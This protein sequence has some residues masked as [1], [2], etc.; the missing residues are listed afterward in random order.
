ML[1]ISTTSFL[2]LC[3]LC[4]NYTS[5][6]YNL[7]HIRVWL[8]YL[9]RSDAHIQSDPVAASYLLLFDHLFLRCSFLVVSLYSDHYTNHTT[10]SFSSH[11][12]STPH[13]TYFSLNLVNTLINSNPLA[14]MASSKK[15]VP[16]ARSPGRPRKGSRDLSKVIGSRVAK[17]V[18]LTAAT[19]L[20][21][22]R[23]FTPK[24]PTNKV[25]GTA[26]G[27]PASNSTLVKRG[28]GRPKK[29]INAEV[30]VDGIVSDEVANEETEEA[31]DGDDGNAEEDVDKG[32]PV[33]EVKRGRGR[34]K[35]ILN[36]VVD[37]DGDET[38]VET[39]NDAIDTTK[40][41][42]RAAE[43]GLHA[44]HSTGGVRRG[45]GRPKIEDNAIDALAPPSP[46]QAPTTVATVKRGRGRPLKKKRLSY[47]GRPVPALPKE[48]SDHGGE[49]DFDGADEDTFLL[50][51]NGPD[52]QKATA[53]QT[54]NNDLFSVTS[55]SSDLP[56]VPKLLPSLMAHSAGKTPS[57]SYH[58]EE[59]HPH[60]MNVDGVG[61][62]RHGIFKRKA[63]E[64]ER[65][66][67]APDDD[68]DH[69]LAPADVQETAPSRPVT[70]FGHDGTHGG[71]CDVNHPVRSM[72]LNSGAVD[73]RE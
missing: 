30:A 19:T 36:A 2:H 68:E 1:T 4:L 73:S 46:A 32:A 48:E 66:E 24:G 17:V 60:Q 7:T 54:T 13:F 53:D 55:S 45:R 50:V 62:R 35:R 38:A 51:E 64:G 29:N 20:R 47:F 37:A 71:G 52:Q 14:I 33:A 34:P 15:H 31:K 57:P 42:D 70:I 56:K 63:G 49:H 27:R 5:K 8:F 26:N 12:R 16:A 23:V 21:S 11:Q 65:L 39:A 22:G 72:F 58:P 18:Q 6:Y 25:V 59:L 43:E 28:R 61:Q 3:L 44:S 69:Q 10:F 41:E 40:V 67:L 9:Q